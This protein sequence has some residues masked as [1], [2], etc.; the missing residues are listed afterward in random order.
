[1]MLQPSRAIGHKCVPLAY[2]KAGPAPVAGECY[3]NPFT[4]FGHEEF[5]RLAKLAQEPPKD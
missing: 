1:M 2:E 3:V 4:D 5:F